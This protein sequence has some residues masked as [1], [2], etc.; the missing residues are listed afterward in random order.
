MEIKLEVHFTLLPLLAQLDFDQNGDI[1]SLE[2]LAI[3]LLDPQTPTNLKII[4]YCIPIF[5]RSVFHVKSQSVYSQIFICS[6]T[7]LCILTWKS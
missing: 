2:F 1:S 6:Q 3:I 7:F 5:W 4:N